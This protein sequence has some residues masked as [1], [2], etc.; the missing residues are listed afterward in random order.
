[1][2]LFSS[3]VGAV[4][5]G[6]IVGG[7]SVIKMA[8]AWNGY[9]LLIW[10]SILLILRTMISS[11]Y[12]IFKFLYLEYNSITSLFNRLTVC[13]SI[14]LSIRGFQLLFIK[15]HINKCLYDI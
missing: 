4:V 3:V 9:L 13:F 5:G 14:L 10:I 1:M 8:G 15:Y 12:L 11:V 2:G 6:A 7:V